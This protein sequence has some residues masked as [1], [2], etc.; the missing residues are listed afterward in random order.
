[1]ARLERQ[2]TVVAVVLPFLGFLVALWLLWGGAVTGLDLAI[3]AVM[4]AAVGFGVTIGYHRLFTHRSFEAKPWLR[5]TL[6]ILGSMAVQGAVIH[7]VADHRKH[8]TFTDEEGDPHSPH[9]NAATGWRGVLAG[10]WH[11]HMG[12]LFDGEHSSARRFAPD[13]R[14]DPMM[15]RIDSLFPLWA[16]L[17]LLIPALA[18]FILSGGEPVAALTA[19]VWAGLV[20]VFLLHHAT[21]SV[22]SICHMYGKRPFETD[23]ESRNNWA[24]AFVSLGEGWHHSHHAFPTSARHGL[25]RLQFD[26]S[27]ALI[28]L[29][30]RLGWASNVKE[31]KPEQVEAKRAGTIP[32][33]PVAEAQPAP[34]TEERELVGAGD[35]S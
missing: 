6:A 10:L 14:K 19:F 3:L 13:L 30:A 35:R 18:G 33:T 15:R 31:P 8:H 34:A 2:I 25:Q 23:D 27:Y 24:V 29:F 4:Y 9:L 32:A 28:K 5:A 20:R 16:L 26:P 12:W 22:N 11:S 1:M 21:W 17:G 7:W